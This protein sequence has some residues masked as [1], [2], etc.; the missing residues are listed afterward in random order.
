MKLQRKRRVEDTARSCAA[1]ENRGGLDLTG[2]ALRRGSG[3]E[4]VPLNKQEEEGSHN[5]R[6]VWAGGGDT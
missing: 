5:N 2:E 6:E 1:A 3:V 4:V